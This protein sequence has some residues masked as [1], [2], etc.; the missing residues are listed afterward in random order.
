[1]N[2]VILMTA[3]PP[4]LGHK[5]LLDFSARFLAEADPRGLVYVILCSRDREPF[6][7]AERMEAL[8][9]A[10]AEGGGNLRFINHHGEEPQEPGDHPDFWEHWKEIIF[11]YVPREENGFVIASD[12]YGADIARAL[13]WEF[14]PCNSYREVMDISATRIRQDPIRYFDQ[15][16]SPFQKL[17]KLTVTL[18][19][20]ESTGKTTMSKGLAASM[21]GYY[22]PEWAREY[23]EVLKTTTVSDRL[24]QRVVEAQHASERAVDGYAGKPFVFRDTD[25]LSTIGYYRIWGRTEPH[26]LR[27]LFAGSKADLYLLMNDGI[28]FTPD[29][30]RLGGDRRESGTAFWQNLLDEF[31]CAYH[32]VQNTYRERQEEEAT[33]VVRSAFLGRLRGLDRFVRG[34]SPGA[35]G[36]AGSR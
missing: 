22:V 34:P 25:L 30:I 8:R 15:I 12:L 4:S 28:P 18:F 3:L 6:T 20:A 21:N 19:G 11:R 26:R 31:G 5:Y 35:A 29:P 17:V 36:T 23:M 1:M 16:V 24:L 2:A 10:T 9:E 33:T 7:G 13:G 27:E 32:V 14:V